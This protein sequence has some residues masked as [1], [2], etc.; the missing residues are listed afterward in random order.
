MQLSGKP[1]RHNYEKG[2]IM[3]TT[4][5]QTAASHNIYAVLFSSLDAH[6]KADGIIRQCGADLLGD[7][8][9][10]T[11]ER[12]QEVRAEFVKEGKE[13]G[14]SDAAIS[15]RW[16]RFMAVCEFPVIK[17]PKSTKAEAVNKSAQ[18]AAFEEKVQ[19]LASGTADTAFIEAE[20]DAMLDLKQAKEREALSTKGKAA[21]LAVQKEAKE[22]AALYRQFAAAYKVREGAEKA[23]NAA[24]IKGLLHEIREALR[25]CDSVYTLEQV[26]ELLLNY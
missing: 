7:C 20:R 11:Y 19:A 26:R 23:A 3:K 13:E 18:R 1:A 10:Q 4:T 22:A 2:N 16:S 5:T 8:D 17:P 25:D 21:K 12:Q 14:L 6:S 15:M 24:R 9:S